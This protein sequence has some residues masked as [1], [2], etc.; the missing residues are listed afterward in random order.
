MFVRCGWEMNWKNDPH[1]CGT[2]SAIVSYVHLKNVQVSSKGFA[3]MTSLMPV[4]CSNQ[5]S[6]E[7]T[8]MWAAQF[9]GLMCSIIPLTGTQEPNKLTRSH[10]SGFIAQLVWA[11]PRHRRGHGL[12]SCWR[13]RKIF[14]VPYEISAEIV[15]QVW[16]SFLRFKRIK[17]TMENWKF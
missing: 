2:I 7:A 10:L 11:L 12:K 13:D 6:Y 14:Q 17:L 15:Q 4:Q 9:V 5:L 3:L 16:G 8:Q 1:T